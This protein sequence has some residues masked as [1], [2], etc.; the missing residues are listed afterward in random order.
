MIYDSH[1]DL[2]DTLHRMN[3]RG[4]IRH[5]VFDANG[6]GGRV[7]VK[8]GWVGRGMRPYWEMVPFRIIGNRIRFR[9][10]TRKIGFIAR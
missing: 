1:G 4:D 2:K 10:K 7:A 6:E 5:F 8:Y 3:T 9:G